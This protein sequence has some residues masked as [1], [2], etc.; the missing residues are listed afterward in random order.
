MYHDPFTHRQQIYLHN[1]E[2]T[3]HNIAYTCVTFHVEADRK[4][5]I[6]V[7]LNCNFY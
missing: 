6:V 3:V 7:S 4:E 5:Y 2:H 1:V